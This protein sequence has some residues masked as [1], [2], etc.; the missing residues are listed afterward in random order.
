MCFGGSALVFTASH[1]DLKHSPRHQHVAIDP[2]QTSFWDDAGAVAVERAGL[3]GFLDLRRSFSSLEL[4]QLL[5]RDA[6]FDLVY[7]DGSHLFEDVFV[8]FYYVAR[9]LA[10]G[11]IVAFD[12]CSDPNV[13]KVL[14]F[15]RKN[16]GGAFQEFGLNLYRVDKGRSWRYR[17]AALQQSAHPEIL[18]MDDG[19]TDGTASLVRNEFP[20]VKLQRFEESKGLIVRRND[21]ARLAEADIIFS[22]DDD[23]AFST[24]TIVAQT[25]VEFDSQRI[26]AIAIPY[27]DINRG[28]EIR[29]RAPERDQIYITDTYIGTAHAVRRDVFLSVGGY[30]EQ[31][32]HQG[33]E[34]DYCLRMFF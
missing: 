10:P 14:A 4:P 17:A 31:L 26:G 20:G 25:L 24:S 33:E 3:E 7:I 15:I 9:L 6:M 34:R 23:A 29:Q 8:D 16:L 2:F 30:R 27:T 12:D 13:A 19:S 11:G 21:A 32:V 1:R 18:V 22:I 5:L 28:P